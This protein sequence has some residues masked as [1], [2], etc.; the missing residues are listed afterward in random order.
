MAT[1]THPRALNRCKGLA[2]LLMAFLAVLAVLVPA[3]G[4]PAP[5][6]AGADDPTPRTVT[7]DLA[8]AKALAARIDKIIAARWQKEGIEPSKPA[9]DYS[10]LRRARIDTNGRIPEVDEAVS[11][12]ADRD[13]AKR[14]RA[15]MGMVGGEEWA[16]HW[17]WVY[18]AAFVG[19]MGGRDQEQGRGFLPL[20]LHE[21]IEERLA[22][23]EGYD[24]IVQEMLGSKGW[25]DENSAVS[26]YLRWREPENALGAASRLFLGTQI[27]CAQCHDHPY[28][29][30]TQKQFFEMAAFFVRLRT[31]NKK[32][33]QPVQPRP[34]M[35]GGTMGGGGM[36]G[37]GQGGSSDGGMMGSG[38]EGKMLDN[39]RKRLRTNRRLGVIQRTGAEIRIPQPGDAATSMVVTGGAAM[40]RPDVVDPRF[41]TG[42]L[43]SRKL[44]AN[45]RQEFARFV[46]TDGMHLFSRAAVNRIWKQMFGRGIVDPV[47][48]L[49]SEASHPELLKLLADEFVAHGCDIRHIQRAILLTRAYA[50]SSVPNE[51]NAADKELYSKAYLR[52]LAPEVLFRSIIEATGADEQPAAG[53]GRKGRRRRAKRVNP[54]QL[55]QLMGRMVYTFDDDEMAEALDYEASIPQ[56]L[57]F[58]NGDL[59]HNGA[60]TGVMGLLQRDLSAKASDD[61]RISH[62]F[63]R[64]LSRPPHRQELTMVRRLLRSAGR[65]DEDRLVIYEDV[66]WALL[67]SSEFFFNH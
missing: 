35:D 16:S 56:A 44:D 64:V 42:A 57:M 51:T 41:I 3:A 31:V 7:N 61:Q 2:A 5:V 12:A 55:L 37:G 19:R 9:D 15:V 38:M 14:D 63:L 67:N 18:T 28:L 59:V 46:V 47:D 8:A 24:T 36:A 21:W 48:D 40:F 32:L 58:L 11:F 6:F 17:A 60:K 53:Q 50:L 30:W 20:F 4:P 33:D 65:S 1:I 49:E 66:Y 62:L 34:G 39:I 52:P 45:R 10:W 27:Q 29:D 25:L 13:P 22:R 26:F 23:G 54:R 43:L